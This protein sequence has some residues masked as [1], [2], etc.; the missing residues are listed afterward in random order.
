MSA[1][2]ESVIHQKAQPPSC[3]HA[4]PGEVRRCWSRH[5]PPIWTSVTHQIKNL[6][7]P[8]QSEQRDA[9]SA[10]PHGD[11]KRSECA[12]SAACFSA[13]FAPKETISDQDNNQD[14]C[15]NITG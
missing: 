15:T 3:L 9:R 2:H 6:P 13:L 1:H 10:E 5:L 14:F 4:E 12:I 8:C 7:F 11:G